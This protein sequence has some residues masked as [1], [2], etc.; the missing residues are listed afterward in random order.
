MRHLIGSAVAVSLLMASVLASGADDAWQP[1][2]AFDAATQPN[3]NAA[4]R[5][6]GR[7]PSDSSKAAD[8]YDLYKLQA[9]PGDGASDGVTV[10]DPIQV[11]G[12]A[13]YYLYDVDAWQA[14]TSGPIIGPLRQRT[15]SLFG[16]DAN[17]TSLNRLTMGS[18]LERRDA[19][20]SH[21]RGSWANPGW[22]F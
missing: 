14:V 16:A 7:L 3:R 17:S 19:G 15:Y 10:R 5:D 6:F 8:S 2:M 1:F 9:D 18:E 22:S 4:Y 20:G 11:F 13:G 21:W 12:Q